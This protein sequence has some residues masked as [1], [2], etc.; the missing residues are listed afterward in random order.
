MKSDA[1]KIKIKSKITSMNG[2]A[3]FT[4]LAPNLNRNPS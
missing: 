1:M 2:P 4:A 3:Q